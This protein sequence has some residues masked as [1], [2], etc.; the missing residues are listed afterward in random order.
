MSPSAISLR[1]LGTTS[2]WYVDGGSMDG[3]ITFGVGD[4]RLWFA[5]RP[6]PGKK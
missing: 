4:A 1:R 3:S 6:A 2:Q 5:K